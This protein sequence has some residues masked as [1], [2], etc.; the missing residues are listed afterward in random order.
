M[1]VEW[2]QVVQQRRQM[3][4]QSILE[5]LPLSTGG[6]AAQTVHQRIAH[7]FESQGILLVECQHGRLFLSAGEGMQRT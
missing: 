5:L 7:M 4:S 6:L 1:P 3:G 2:L